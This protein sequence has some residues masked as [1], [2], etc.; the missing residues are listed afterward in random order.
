MRQA[1]Q[2]VGPPFAFIDQI[3]LR[4]LF[5]DAQT[6]ESLCFDAFQTIVDAP[7]FD[8]LCFRTL[9]LKGPEFETFKAI[10]RSVLQGTQLDWAVRSR[11]LKFRLPSPQGFRDFDSQYIL[12]LQTNLEHVVNGVTIT[13]DAA[14]HAEWILRVAQG[15]GHRYL[16][17]LVAA[18]VSGP[19]TGASSGM[20]AGPS[21]PEGV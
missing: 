21:A 8:Y 18:R 9:T 6:V 2:D 17:E 10:L 7:L 11:K 13:L 15:K 14:E 12:S 5:T 19:S 3:D 4:L 1:G 16:R 20:V